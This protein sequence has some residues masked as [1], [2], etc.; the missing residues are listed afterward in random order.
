MPE[1]TS[2]ARF[3]YVDY[4]RV[5]KAKAVHRDGVCRGVLALNPSG[6]C[7]RVGVEPD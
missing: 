4:A 3:V 2:W 7:T 5:P 6:R 1:G